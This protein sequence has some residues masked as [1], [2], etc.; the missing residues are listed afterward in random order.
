MPDLEGIMTD[1]PTLTG[2]VSSV[3]QVY[4]RHPSIQT[5]RERR[6]GLDEGVIIASVEKDRSFVRVDQQHGD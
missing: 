4:R 1:L 2:G 5:L 3:G 6:C